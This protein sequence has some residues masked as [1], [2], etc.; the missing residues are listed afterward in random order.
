MHM[1]S[2]LNAH[3]VARTDVSYSKSLPA[4]GAY[5][6]EGNRKVRNQLIQ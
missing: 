4:I 6:K 3:H 2:E 5:V 1:S